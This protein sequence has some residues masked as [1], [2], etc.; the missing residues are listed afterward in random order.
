V[1]QN[2]L[3]LRLGH[4]FKGIGL[5]WGIVCVVQFGYP[6]MH[7]KNG[8]DVHFKN[9]FRHFAIQIESI[10]RHNIIQCGIFKCTSHRFIGCGVRMNESAVPQGFAAGHKFD[11]ASGDEIGLIRSL[12][13]KVLNDILDLVRIPTHTSEREP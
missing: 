5:I 2:R 6:P 3:H 10:G 13:Q 1:I 4:V 12:F 7:W 11:S 9:R 8:G